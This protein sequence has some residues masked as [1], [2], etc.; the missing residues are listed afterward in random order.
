MHGAN[1]A[2]AELARG[3]AD[4]AP[5][6]TIEIVIVIG[7]LAGFAKFST[8]PCLAPPYRAIPYC[9]R[10]TPEHAHWLFR[11]LNAVAGEYFAQTNVQCQAKRF[12]Q[13]VPHEGWAIQ[14]GPEEAVVNQLLAWQMA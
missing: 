2:L 11:T 6:L 12:R 13:A 8:Q 14:V 1:G 5:E 3:D 4:L 9:Y 7:Q 10:R